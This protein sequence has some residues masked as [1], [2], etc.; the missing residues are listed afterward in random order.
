MEGCALLLW[1]EGIRGL[2]D[3]AEFDKSL[4]ASALS[5]WYLDY[6]VGNIGSMLLIIEA[7]ARL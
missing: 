3:H 5:E 4:R 2:C 6:I 1:A 7:P